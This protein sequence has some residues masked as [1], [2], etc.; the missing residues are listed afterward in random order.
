MSAGAPIPLANYERRL[1][2]LERRCATLEKENQRLLREA[3]LTHPESVRLAKTFGSEDYPETGSTLPIQFV[4]GSLEDD[5]WTPGEHVATYQPR[6]ASMQT[7]A[8]VVADTWLPAGTLV[9]VLRANRRWWIIDNV[10]RKLARGCVAGTRSFDGTQDPGTG[11]SLGGQ[12]TYSDNAMALSIFSPGTLYLNQGDLLEEFTAPGSGIAAVKFK[13][14]SQGMVFFNVAMSSLSQSGASQKLGR[15]RVILSP[16]TN[17]FLNV[18]CGGWFPVVQ[19]P[20]GFATDPG[21][22]GW[23]GTFASAYSAGADG[24]FGIGMR[25]QNFDVNPTVSVRIQFIELPD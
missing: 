4:D 7:T 6:S 5:D 23:E 13:R 2:A 15:F 8:Q 20:N 3:L 22:F 24:Y 1:Q 21:S 18:D 11:T 9:R 10:S 19:N 17:F 16:N 12:A 14:A 25:K